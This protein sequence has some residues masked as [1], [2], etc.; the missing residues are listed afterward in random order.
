MLS[1]SREDTRVK[2]RVSGAWE[3][4]PPSPASPPLPPGSS[5]SFP[6]GQDPLCPLSP[7]QSFLRLTSP[8][9]LA[10]SFHVHLKALL[11]GKDDIKFNPFSPLARRRR[12]WC[13][14]WAGKMVRLPQTQR[15]G[16]GGETSSIEAE[17]GALGQLS[18]VR[19]P[20]SAPSSLPSEK[21]L[22]TEPGGCMGT[23]P[24]TTFSK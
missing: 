14:G 20:S 6:P 5:P 4:G 7:R 1:A 16:Q 10:F 22:P 19:N 2:G 17:M 15:I 9:C 11:Q 8:I 24:M 23:G 21:S 3:P 12:T 18:I 13:A